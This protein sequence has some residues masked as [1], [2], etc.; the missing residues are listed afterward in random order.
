M[1]TPKKLFKVVT[2][3]IMIETYEVEASTMAEAKSAC[4]ECWTAEDNYPTNVE[5][6]EQYFSG[7]SVEHCE[8]FGIE[9]PLDKYDNLS[10]QSLGWWRRPTI[11][12]L[13][14]EEIS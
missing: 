14:S 12:E 8:L 10:T 11:Q 4:F 5:R 1:N 9:C 13:D 3:N 7:K 2:H 6:I